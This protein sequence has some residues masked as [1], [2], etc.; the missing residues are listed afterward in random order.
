MLILT[1]MICFRSSVYFL[2]TRFDVIA[3]AV[4]L[5]GSGCEIDNAYAEVLEQAESKCLLV[6][7]DSR[8]LA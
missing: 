8:V 2:A 3:P 7:Y 4:V 6:L 5:G 1:R